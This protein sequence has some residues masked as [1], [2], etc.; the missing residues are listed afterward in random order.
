MRAALAEALPD[1][2]EAEIA[3][4][5]RQG[6]GSPG[7][8]LALRDLDVEGLDRNL[9]GLAQHGLAD[10][11]KRAALIQ[12]LSGKVA[13]P[14]YEAFLARVPAIIAEQARKRHGAALGKAVK[15]WEEASR[16]ADRAKRHSL[17]PA[18]TTFLL[19]GMVAELAE[20]RRKA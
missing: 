10:G 4:L 12:G 20:P 11:S 3:A 13:Q 16:L 1:A 6:G 14:R 15:L 9:R 19:A 17:D 8:A 5:V 18:T 7:A 2:N